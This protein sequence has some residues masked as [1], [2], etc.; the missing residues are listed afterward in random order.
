L[1][2]KISGRNISDKTKKALKNC[3]KYLTIYNAKLDSYGNLPS[4]KIE[5]DILFEVLYDLYQAKAGET[6]DHQE[7]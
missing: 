2:I 7:M 1:G 3:K 6:E 5:D 4:G